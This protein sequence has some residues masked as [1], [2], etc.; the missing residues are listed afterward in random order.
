MQ[1]KILLASGSSIRAQI[2]QNAGILFDISKPDVDEDQIKKTYLEKNTGLNDIAMRLAEAKALAVTAE[3]DQF[4][5]GSDQIMVHKETLYDKPKTI[6]EAKERLLRLKNGPHQLI[7]AVTFARNGKIVFRNIESSTLYLR[8]F[9]REELD[10]YFD[11]VGTD[12]LQSVGAYQIEKIGSRL[13][14]HIDGNHFAVL[15]LS[16][17]PVLKFLREQNVLKY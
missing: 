9:S 2:L 10:Q 16:L 15:G 17:F 3:K 8:D 4:V 7:N 6:E 1:E 5:L 11:E 14:T 12:I 13:F